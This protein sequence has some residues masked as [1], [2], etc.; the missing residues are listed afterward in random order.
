V[1]ISEN[2]KLFVHQKPHPVAIVVVRL[3]SRIFKIQIFTGLNGAC[4]SL[5]EWLGMEC[6]YPT[7]VLIKFLTSGLPTSEK[8]TANKD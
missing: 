7:L 1:K 3:L 8:Y 5:W 6:P 2:K 4:R